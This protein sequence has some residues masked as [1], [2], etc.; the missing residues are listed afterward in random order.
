MTGLQ[1]NSHVN[2]FGDYVKGGKVGCEKMGYT[3][4]YRFRGM[5]WSLVASGGLILI[6]NDEK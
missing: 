6:I 5:I 2:G 3:L 4:Y 1:T